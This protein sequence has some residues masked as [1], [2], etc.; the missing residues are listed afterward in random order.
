MGGCLIF[1]GIVLFF[2]M[3]RSTTGV[4]QAIYIAMEWVLVGFHLIRSAILERR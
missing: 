2:L 3:S 4:E 1:V